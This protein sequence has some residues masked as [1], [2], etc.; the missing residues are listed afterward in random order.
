MKT[1]QI[2]RRLKQLVRLGGWNVDLYFAED[3]HRAIAKLKR[4]VPKKVKIQEKVFLALSAKK[5][6][7]VD[8]YEPK[9]CSHCGQKLQWV[10]LDTPHNQ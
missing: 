8:T 5:R 9:F 7:F 2:I 6:L 1:K 4:D 3:I 10:S